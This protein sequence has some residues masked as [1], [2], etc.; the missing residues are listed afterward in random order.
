MERLPDEPEFDPVF[1]FE[2]QGDSAWELPELLRRAGVACYLYGGNGIFIR[3]EPDQTVPGELY[4]DSRDLPL[5]KKC[6]HLLSGPPKPVDEEALMEAYDEYMEAGEAEPEPE[7]DPE[8]EATGD[9]AWKVF[10]CLAIVVVAC[11]LARI[12]LK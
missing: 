6:L 12:F 8:R 10:L 1:F 3:M 5:A 9:V 4:V 2:T 11:I 7:T